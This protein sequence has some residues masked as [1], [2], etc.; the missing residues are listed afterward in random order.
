MIVKG[1]SRA[2]P[3][4]LAYHLLRTDENER[5]RVLES[6][7]IHPDR[8]QSV[9]E[10]LA[11]FQDASLATKG[12]KG[13]YH[14]N[15]DPQAHY[16]MS[17]AEWRRA[18]EILEQELGYHNQPRLVIQHTKNGREHIHV[19]WQRTDT[20][21]FRLISDSMNY[22][23]HEV[24]A[25]QMERE[26]GHERVPGAFTRLWNEHTGRPKEAR[27]VSA[28]DHA[29]WQQGQRTAMSPKARKEQ[30]TRLWRQS[31][32]GKAFVAALGQAGYRLV[33]GDQ[34]N[35]HMLVD[36]QGE[37][38]RLRQ[39]LQGTAKVKD[40]KAKLAHYPLENLPTVD[41]VREMQRQQARRQETQKRAQELDE[42][43]RAQRRK[44]A[45]QRRKHQQFQQHAVDSTRR[46]Q[47]KPVR[48]AQTARKRQAQQGVHRAE[49]DRQNRAAAAKQLRQARQAAEHQRRE[50]AAALETLIK[51]KIQAFHLQ[52]GRERFTLRQRH[53]QQQERERHEQAQRFRTGFLGHVDRLTGKEARVR[54]ANRREA[55]EA[56][57]HRAGQWQ[58][59]QTD[60]AK[61]KQ[62][63][64]REISA[65]KK[66]QAQ[67]L[68][69]LERGQTL[70]PTRQPSPARQ[71]GESER[72]ASE[73][74]HE[75]S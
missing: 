37:A 3:N 16:R 15:I 48:P 57:Q 42:Q 55:Q 65:F 39:L 17:E 74:S 4:A 58:A 13:L 49:S 38:F 43:R 8:R 50:R 20:E 64:D 40:I 73:F 35:I 26:F 24:A 44:Q 33:R 41:R 66:Q 14:A 25:R 75:R 72:R 31:D 53:L 5:V 6:A 45:E 51:R 56:R 47:P 59:L 23:K 46:A 7:A 21:D 60:Q 70:S 1:G 9:H 12:W 34:A 67:S 27:P 63:F 29:Q 62:M 69:A 36:H 68:K 22:K 61:A 28:F 54:A 32:S 52:Q 30:I 18:V 11:M 10:S 2:G 19:V 71:P